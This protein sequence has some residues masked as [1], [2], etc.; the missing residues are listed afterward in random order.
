MINERIAKWQDTSETGDAFFRLCFAKGDLLMK[1][2][3]L[4]AL[5]SL[6]LSA[7]LILGLCGCGGAGEPAGDPGAGE[8]SSDPDDPTDSS[9]PADP[10]DPNVDTDTHAHQTAVEGLVPNDPASASANTLA[11]DAAI[12]SAKES[13]TL[14]VGEGNY[15][16]SS[17]SFFGDR[18]TI[19][20]SNKKDL[21]IRGEAGQTTFINTSYS[22]KER[23]N[24]DTYMASNFF[25]ITGSEEIAIEGI[26]FDYLSPTNLSAEVTEVSDGG[27]YTIL[28]PLDASD[29]V[30]G[31]EYVFCVNVFS[32]DGRPKSETWIESGNPAELL[33]QSDGTFRLP[34]IYGATGDL[35]CARFTS[36]TYASPLL[37][38][39]DTRGLTVRDCR[40]YACP[41][42]TVY[43]P[44]GNAD[45][46]FERFCI[47]N[48]EGEHSLFCSNEDGIHIK[49]LRGTL[50]VRDCVFEGMGDDALNIHSKAAAVS[51]VS[52]NVVVLKDGRTGGALDANWAQVGD[53][54]DFY[55]TDLVKLGTAAIVCMEESALTFDALPTGVGTGVILQNISNAPASVTV[56]RT[57]VVRSR[58]RAFLLQCPTVTVSDCEIRDTALSAVLIAPDIG[59]WYEMGPTREV[60]IENCTFTGC[61]TR[62][63][64][65]IA[66]R[67]CHDDASLTAVSAPLHGN[68]TVR[69]CAFSD[70]SVGVYAR[71]VESLTV[72]EDCTFIACSKRV[73][74]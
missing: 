48:R 55:S 36:G 64:A 63:H 51:S 25:L 28:R 16:F 20:V 32:S 52:E 65:A 44:G 17:V 30:T 57:S 23:C 12:S 13:T 33:A 46:T 68:V 53:T 60:L 47:G 1:K 35:V 34:G 29:G 6:I 54:V 7:L 69:G 58:A 5:L 50:T 18:F 56:I 40:V 19:A 26:A 14:L 11:L 21:T 67:A 22:P 74:Q 45:F 72:T 38:V 2:Y 62:S 73:D 41:S 27:N 15:Y 31:G 9:G 61:G 24:P 10:A 39:Q 37:Y 3:R 70:C 8:G 4:R 49:G 42:A 43:A 66:V 59:Q 71:R